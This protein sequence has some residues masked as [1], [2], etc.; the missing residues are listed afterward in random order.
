MVTT[1]TERYAILDS[2]YTEEKQSRRGMATAYLSWEMQ[3]HN[4]E[5]S[6][7]Q[8]AT[9]LLVTCV[10]TE[11]ADF[12]RKLKK[13]YPEKTIIVGGAASTLPHSLGLYCDCVCV[14]DGQA[15]LKVLFE[16]GKEAAF[17]LP[18]A[19]INGEARRVTIDH[20]FP[21][22]MPPIQAED[23][24]YRVW[25]GRGCKNKCKFCQTGWGYEYSENPN[26][27][28]LLTQ[29]HQ[30]LAE[31][32]KVVYLSNDAAQHSFYHEL[33]ATVHGSFSV[34]HL[35]KHG[36]PPARVVRLGVEGV[37][38][39]LRRSVAKPISYQDLLDCTIWLNNN[40]KSV[41]WFMIAGLPGETKEDW[42]E[43]KQIIQEWKM[44]T[45]RGIIT[46]SFTA[47]CP[48][49]ATPYATVAIDDDY[50]GWY[51]EFN[52]WFYNGIGWSNRITLMK[53][54]MP[55]ARM[56]SVIYDLGLT[57]E[58]IRRGGGY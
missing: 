1:Q 2:C 13:K 14:G 38:E 26:P 57:E 15:F 58:E 27:K 12:L 35:K 21:W 34:G 51:D 37:S 9:I 48:E 24:A 41:R 47:F 3:R 36:L 30:L 28:Q 31:G 29:T 40:K 39:R 42:D 17:A 56:K 4:I 55:K 46:I 5:E 7:V 20:N 6:T 54:R 32:K 50:W 16:E 43:L 23:K 52:E 33:P 18:N 44:R 49:P 25:C 53:P 10:S 11:A 22:D 45:T 19:W 8:E